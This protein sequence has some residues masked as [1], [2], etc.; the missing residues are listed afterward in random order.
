MPAAP[1]ANLPDD[2]HFMRIALQQAQEAGDAG[3]VP[4]GAVLVRDGVVLG[5]GR[6]RP[7]HDSDPS[8]H[9][10]M[11]ALRQAAKR[12]GNYRLDDCTLY[13]TLEP[14]AMC[15]G[16]LL[17]ARLRRV[18]FGAAD[19]K[20]GCA[21]SVLNLFA[22]PQLN[23]Q[24]ALCGGVL[25]EAAAA[26][27]QAFFRQRRQWQKSSAVPLREDALRSPEA[28]F[29]GLVP[30]PWPAH[31]LS[32]LPSLAGLRLHYLD[33][34]GE[35]GQPVLLCLHP[36]TAW[37]Y[38]LHAQMQAWVGQGARVLVPDLIGFGRSDKPKRE[39]AHQPDF[40]LQYL[41]EWLQRLDLRQVTLVLPA[42]GH[43]LAQAL[44]QHAADRITLQQFLPPQALEMP[45][46]A[47]GAPYPDAG[48]C[49]GERAFAEWARR[50]PIIPS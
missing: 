42:D 19:S 26:Q 25:A 1:D 37:S 32:D 22:Q 45:A 6:N 20:T 10:E 30:A 47:R 41:L 12:L 40:H 17:H 50:A 11:V 35:A 9:A 14:C 2:A 33:T 28:A 5:S 13:V 4:V 29:A 39:D 34:G 7:I 36:T 38:G 15:C 31:Y 48:H 43:P 49:A 3:E 46:A 21:G 18:V 23:H 27:L 24:T 8:A 44:V 16:A